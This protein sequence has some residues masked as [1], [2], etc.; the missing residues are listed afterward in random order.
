MQVMMI[1]HKHVSEGWR[2]GR[3]HPTKSRQTTTIMTNCLRA[4]EINYKSGKR[5][6]IG[7]SGCHPVEGLEGGVGWGGGGL[8][9]RPK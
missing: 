2:E 4:N 6:R 9:A 5:R 7:F 1:L 3:D 8:R